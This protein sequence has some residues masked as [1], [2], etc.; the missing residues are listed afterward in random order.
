M[1][2]RFN[3]EIFA[4]FGFWRRHFSAY[5]VG[6]RFYYI[7]VS[8]DIKTF[9]SLFFRQSLNDKKPLVSVIFPFDLSFAVNFSQY[10]QKHPKA[11]EKQEDGQKGKIWKRDVFRVPVY[12]S[13]ERNKGLHTAKNGVCDFDPSTRPCL[14]PCLERDIRRINPWEINTI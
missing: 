3:A 6:T 10:A 13:V 11:R 4:R 1:L 8:S 9:Q 12:R 14:D 5:V 7:I 2:C